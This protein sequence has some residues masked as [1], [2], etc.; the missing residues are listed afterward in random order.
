[1][2]LPQ[3]RK[4]CAAATTGGRLFFCFCFFLRSSFTF[5]WWWWWS[6]WWWSDANE[7]TNEEE[8]GQQRQ[9]LACWMSEWMECLILLFFQDPG[10][11]PG[12]SRNPICPLLFRNLLFFL[13]VLL[14]LSQRLSCFICLLSDA[15]SCSLLCVGIWAIL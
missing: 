13:V 1:M 5:R 11:N 6:V 9:Q 3:S 7:W 8:K 14:S 12:T 4:V 2:H 15:I 10:T